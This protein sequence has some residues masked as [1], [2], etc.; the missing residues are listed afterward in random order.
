[1]LI[2]SG[3]F[4]TFGFIDDIKDDYILD[5][6]G[7]ENLLFEDERK[8]IFENALGENDMLVE[9]NRQE[10]VL[11]D[12]KKTFKFWDTIFLKLFLNKGK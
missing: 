4:I 7:F 12:F 8:I 1:M 3:L 2:I 11:F 9:R 5:K 10:S 6:I